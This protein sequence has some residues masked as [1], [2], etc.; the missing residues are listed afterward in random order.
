MKLTKREQ[1]M[2]TLEQ[3]ENALAVAETTLAVLCDGYIP[4]TIVANVRQ[5]INR[6]SRA[7]KRIEN[8]GCDCL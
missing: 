8:I 1:K 2:T 4:A 7:L 5:D 3:A 6:V